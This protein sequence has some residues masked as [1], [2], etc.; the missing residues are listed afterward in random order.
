[1]G[2]RILHVL[3]GMNRAGV[4]TWLMH[5]LRHIDRNRF[6]MDFLVHDPHRGDYEDEIV[7]LGSRVLRCL[8]PRR[9]WTFAAN[10]RRVLHEAGPYDVVHS[11]VHHFSGFVLRLARAGGVRARIAHSH[12]DTSSLDARGS[13]PRQAYL[14]ICRHWIRRHATAKLACSQEAAGALF[15]RG[16]AN[17]PRVQILHCG[18]DMTPFSA[19]A[20]RAAVRAELG[21]PD[22]AFVL[23]HV[24]R[25]CAAKNH[26]FLLEV[27]ARVA[28][29][30]PAAFVLLVGEGTLETSLREKAN[31]LGLSGR[32]IFAGSRGDVPRLM[33]GGMDIFLF[34][35]LFE[36]LGLAA[37]E[38]Q[39]AGLRCVFS[40]V[41]PQEAD[42]VLPLVQRLPLTASVDTWAAA[43][44]AHC[45]RSA[46]MDQRT[47]LA[48]V[49]QSP[50]S[51]QCSLRRLESTYAG[52]VAT[53][54]ARRA[55]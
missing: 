2:L 11:H 1:M 4:E 32:V 21:I 5:V 3:A 25:F 37:V 8:Q 48:A 46:A 17:D 28:Q 47:A 18:L 10:F 14:R 13:L 27:A 23:G 26:S 19:P 35:S 39:A 43:I 22:G 49:Q 44:L 52:Q 50:F 34:P 40:S 31:R 7:A 9:P 15:G 54:S 12:S 24:G 41:V 33:L 20:A 55:A 53:S 16:W 30:H 38:A 45:G 29:R 42:V 51:I 6:Q 36:G